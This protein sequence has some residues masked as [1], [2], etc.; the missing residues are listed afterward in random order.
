MDEEYKSLLKIFLKNF[1]R[2][3]ERFRKYCHDERCEDIFTCPRGHENCCG[4][5]DLDTAIAWIISKDIK[6]L[7]IV[8]EDFI[9]GYADNKDLKYAF[10]ELYLSYKKC[11]SIVA[12]HNDGYLELYE[13]LRELADWIYSFKIL[14]EKII[15]EG[16]D[17][18]V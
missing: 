17:S 10:D 16:A 13:L 1:K 18:D 7:N 9:E 11:I 14:I 15:L 12:F 3:E 6:Y 4:K 2:F 8:I 5:L